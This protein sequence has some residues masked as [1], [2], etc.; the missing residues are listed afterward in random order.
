MNNIQLQISVPHLT[1]SFTVTVKSDV[2][3]K[4]LYQALIKKIDL[5]GEER[6]FDLIDKRMG[7]KIY[8]NAEFLNQKLQE[9]G[10]KHGHA[11]V[12]KEDFKGG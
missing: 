12:L 4:Q 5:D 6:T 8:P 11:I 9:V 7:R 2:T 10:F 3:V 1:K